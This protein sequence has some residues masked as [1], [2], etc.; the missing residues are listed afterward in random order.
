MSSRSYIRV[1]GSENAS[2]VSR[3]GSSGVDLQRGR[4]LPRAGEPGV[5]HPAVLNP[6]ES[7]QCQ[8]HREKDALWADL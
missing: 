6:A 1:A 3:R 2:D 4:M 7:F 5:F 8:S